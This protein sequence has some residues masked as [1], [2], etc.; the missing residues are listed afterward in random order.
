V[1]INYESACTTSVLI[2]TILRCLLDKSTRRQS[3]RGLVNSRTSQLSNNEFKKRGRAENA[4]VKNAGVEKSGVITRGNPS[5]E[6]TIR[7]R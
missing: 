6:K 1:S 5:E 3:G 4:V 2:A 7:Y